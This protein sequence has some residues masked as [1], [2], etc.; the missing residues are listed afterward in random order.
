MGI[1]VVQ[2]AFAPPSPHLY[3]PGGTNGTTKDRNKHKITLFGCKSAPLESK[4][5][6][7]SPQTKSR[8]VEVGLEMSRTKGRQIPAADNEGVQKNSTRLTAETGIT[9]Q[10][11][12][13]EST[14]SEPPVEIRTPSHVT[15]KESE[16]TNGRED[17]GSSATQKAET[18][19]EDTIHTN[20]SAKQCPATMES[21]CNEN[22]VRPLNFFASLTTLS[23]LFLI[24]NK[25][26][27]LITNQYF[28]ICYLLLLEKNRRYACGLRCKSLNRG[29]I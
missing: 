2:R 6:T 9:G 29:T 13:R 5:L 3:N 26:I 28:H 19:P 22:E 8:S 17:D 15:F 21:G 27:N 24:I 12:D 4:S 7:Q 18:D 25:Y 23:R 14:E 16:T 11:I 10:E 20:E 1:R